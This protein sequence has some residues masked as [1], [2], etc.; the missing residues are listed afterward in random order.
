MSFLRRD[1][2]TLIIADRLRDGDLT[3]AA[4]VILQVGL[5]VE[6]GYYTAEAHGARTIWAN[7]WC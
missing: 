7:D 2:G 5:A 3:H 4:F 1:A 6:R